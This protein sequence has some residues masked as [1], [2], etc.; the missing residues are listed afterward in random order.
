VPK[1]LISGAFVTEEAV[2]RKKEEVID[3]DL[4]SENSKLFGS[5]QGSP[6]FAQVFEISEQT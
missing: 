5:L 4:A 2:L 1:T 6:T 3:K